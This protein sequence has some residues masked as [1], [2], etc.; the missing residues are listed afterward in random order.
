MERLTV[1]DRWKV[2]QGFVLQIVVITLVLVA[3]SAM[4]FYLGMKGLMTTELMLLAVA[5][6]TALIHRTSLREVFP[7]RKFTVLEFLGLLCFFTGGYL[8]N[9]LL[10]GLSM[11][12]I[13]SSQGETSYIDAM[14]GES[15]ALV[16]LIAV[17]V[18]PAVCEEA[19]ERGAVMSHFRSVRRE[20]VVVLVMGI[21]FGVFHMSPGRFLNTA[22]MGALL[23]Y[24]MI[25]K[26]NILF[27]MILH[28][29]NNLVSMMPALADASMYTP[30]NL[31]SFLLLSFA[32]PLFLAIGNRLM[33]PDAFRRRHLIVAGA[34]SLILLITGLG[35]TYLDLSD[36][37]SLRVY[38]EEIHN[39]AMFFV[40]ISTEY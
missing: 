26:N 22:C 17:A 23:T 13:P 19:V 34:L 39:D 15:G 35:G 29:M 8:M 14:V 20:W 32:F 3:G 16:S 4:E 40:N 7:I 6:V 12:F 9:V 27:P 10:T 24:I 37:S 33:C 18:L 2:W 38:S 30:H 36:S 1:Q 25:R 5:V 28:F 21:F 11:V 31:S